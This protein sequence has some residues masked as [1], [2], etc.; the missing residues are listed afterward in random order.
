LAAESG[1]D[2]YEHLSEG[3]ADVP[4]GAEGLIWLPYLNGERTPHL[5]ANARGV[6]FGLTPRH[7]KAHVVRAIME[8]VAF[9]LLD[10]LEIIRS[11]TIPIREIRVTG[12]G[13]ASPLWRQIMADTFGQP[14]HAI[15][16][17]EGPAYGAAMLAGV[18]TGIYSDCA[19]AARRLIKVG[20]ET[21]PNAGASAE[22]ARVYPLYGRLYRDLKPTFAAAAA[23]A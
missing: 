16:A 12:G 17:G 14:V 7:R 13:S 15:Q 1:K 22:Y 20:S 10:S 3:A 9:G 23:Q 21:R 11:L 5:D 2:A 4:P 6:L 18:G 8:G 19:D